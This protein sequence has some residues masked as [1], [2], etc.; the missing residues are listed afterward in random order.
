MQCLCSLCLNLNEMTAT[1]LPY[2]FCI[3]SLVFH[4][5]SLGHWMV[6]WSVGHGGRV[7]AECNTSYF[8]VKCK[9]EVKN[10]TVCEC[11]DV[12]FGICITFCYFPVFPLTLT[13]TATLSMYLL[14]SQTHA[15]IQLYVYNACSQFSSIFP[16]LFCV[17]I[18]VHCVLLT[19]TQA[20]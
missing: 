19:Q 10:C 16:V 18:L 13:L 4:Q 3:H 17:R 15:Y 2:I 20:L 14:S 5:F 6:G 8:H 12:Y 1:L 11:A 9:C 7:S